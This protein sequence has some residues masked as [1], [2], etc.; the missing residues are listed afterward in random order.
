[1][2]VTEAAAVLGVTP[3]AVQRRIKR[4][5]MIAERMGP[6]LV[7]SATE[8]DRW[9]P[10]GKRKGGRPRKVRERGGEQPS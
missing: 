6:I 9:K 10:V 1:M 2:T 5:E 4:G 7:I 3:R 8:V